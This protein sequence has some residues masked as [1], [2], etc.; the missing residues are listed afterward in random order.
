VTR[1]EW[2]YKTLGASSFLVTCFE[3]G[4]D[5]QILFDEKAAQARVAELNAARVVKYGLQRRLR[6]A[7]RAKR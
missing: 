1:H 5:D 3:C 6:I 2:A 7:K 4:R